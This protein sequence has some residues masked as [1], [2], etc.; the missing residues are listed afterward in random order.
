MFLLLQTWLDGRN[1]SSFGNLTWSNNQLSFSIIATSGAKNINAMLP[2]FS[3][4]G[5]QLSSITRN[6]G[7]VSFTTQTIKGI[8]YAFFAPVTG[9]FTYIAT[10]NAS[11]A[12][13]AAPPVVTAEPEQISAEKT[14]QEP[15]AE[16]P[17]PVSK[18]SI[19]V[20]P[21]P[22]V[23]YFN[24]IIN[25]IEAGPVTIRVLDIFGKTV[26]KHEKVSAGSVRTGQTLASGTYYAEVT[27]GDQRKVVKIV[28]VN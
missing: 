21:N 22:S 3:A 17:L 27:Q 12:R 11:G 23:D 13:I 1:S 10:Y 8:Q 16:E 14:P 2:L 4:T 9:T 5:G 7:S 15:I 25:S 19:N 26:E 24:I 18:L 20:M 6:G 28:K